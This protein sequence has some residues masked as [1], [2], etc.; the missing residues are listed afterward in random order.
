MGPELSLRLCFSRRLWLAVCD[1]IASGDREQEHTI[2]VRVDRRD[3]KRDGEK[4]REDRP[5]DDHHDADT[6]V[7]DTRDG[8]D[9]AQPAIAVRRRPAT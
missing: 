6:A 7:V 1:R 5:S 4:G 3:G 9:D 8:R 2:Q